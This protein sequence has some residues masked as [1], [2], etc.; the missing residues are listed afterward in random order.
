MKQVKTNYLHHIQTYEL[1]PYTKF[2]D[3]NKI[4]RHHKKGINPP[5][6]GGFIF[7]KLTKL[8]FVEFNIELFE[9]N[10]SISYYKCIF[11]R[12]DFI[13][14]SICIVVIQINYVQLMLVWQVCLYII[15]KIGIS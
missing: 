3:A 2:R 5:I 10:V 7:P 11:Y 15:F 9:N 14:R 8:F 1:A 13:V 4:K 6:L 12:M